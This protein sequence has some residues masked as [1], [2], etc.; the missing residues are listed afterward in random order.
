MLK[1]S[2]FLNVW[3]VVP[4]CDCCRSLWK[5]DLCTMVLP[6][7]DKLLQS[8]YE[9]WVKSIIIIIIRLLM[10]VYTAC[11]CVCSYMQTGCMSLKLIMKHFWT[12]ISDTLKATPSVGVD[13]T[14]EERWVYTDMSSTRQTS[15]DHRCDNVTLL[16]AARWHHS[17]MLQTDVS[18]RTRLLDTRYDWYV[19][20]VLPM[21]FILADTT[22]AEFAANS[23]RTWATWWRTGQRRSV[24][25]AA[26]SESCSCSWHLLMM[27]C[28]GPWTQ[29][30]DC[31][32][33]AD[34]QKTSS[35]FCVWTRQQDKSGES[36][37]TPVCL[38]MEKTF[39]QEKTSK[40]SFKGPHDTG[41]TVAAPLP[42]CVLS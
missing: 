13:I 10:S 22:S 3:L 33:A 28:D 20:L 42:F 12:L 21:F 35:A 16:L 9:R 17:C 40:W 18:F 6:Q 34:L 14:R 8:K 15:A 1:I 41:T 38:K 27:C 23:W 25:T 7:I 37:E 2:V 19:T 24:A 36:T 39:L 4:C 5:L 31:H 29:Q 30:G 11:V 32:V 26:P